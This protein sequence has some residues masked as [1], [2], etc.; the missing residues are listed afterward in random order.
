LQQ[1]ALGHPILTNDKKVAGTLYCSRIDRI[2]GVQISS[3]PSSKVSATFFS[4]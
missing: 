3:G 2:C 1:G 4:E